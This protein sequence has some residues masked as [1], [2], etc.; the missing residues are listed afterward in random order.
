MP[1]FAQEVKEALREGVEIKTGVIVREIISAGGAVAGLRCVRVEQDKA[2][3][4]IFHEIPGSEFY[5]EADRVVSAIGEE[6]G[7]EG[8]PDGLQKK[9][10]KILVNE[11]GMTSIP[12]VYAGGDLI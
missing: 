8:L 5:L 12:R 2:S 4:E 9:G 7:L 10:G 3:R 11:Y 6:P 1:A